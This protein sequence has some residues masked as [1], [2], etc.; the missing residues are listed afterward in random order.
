MRYTVL[1]PVRACHDGREVPLGSPQQRAALAVLALRGGVH[2]TA[3]DLSTALWG[4]ELP[5]SA[6]RTVRTY[7]SRLRAV[8]VRETGD[9]R[10]ESTGRGYLLGVPAD[11]LDATVFTRLVT[12]AEEAVRRGDAPDAAGLLDTALD[13]W[14]GTPLAGLPGPYAAAQRDR[15]TQMH[16][17]AVESRLACEIALGRYTGALADLGLHL[18]EHPLRERLSELRMLALYRTGRQAEAVAAFHEVRGRLDAE[19]GILP[20]PAL[21]RLYTQIL[22]ADPALELVPA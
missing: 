16:H 4:T 2:V 10:I 18:A 6:V 11:A 20:G 19:L 3:D 9:G 13:L 15:L 14:R 5:R 8:F 7:I 12:R 21:Q 17:A 22:S 1:G